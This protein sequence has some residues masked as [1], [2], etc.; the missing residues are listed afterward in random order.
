MAADGGPSGSTEPLVYVVVLSWNRAATTLRCIESVA[1]SSYRNA[2]V[3]VVDNA[4]ADDSVARIRERFPQVPLIQ[5]PANLGYA[6]GN[7][8]GIRY[9]MERGAEFVLVLNDDVF[10]EPDALGHMVAAAG[11]GVAAVGCKVRLFDEPDR[12]WAAGDLNFRTADA[13]P[14]DDGRFDAP[15]DLDYAVGCC[16]LLRAG[17]LDEIGR[18]DPSYFLEFEEVDWC[19]RARKAGHRIVYEP[20]AV[21]YHNHSVSFTDSCSPAFHYLSARNCL[22]FWKRNDVVLSGRP[23]ALYGLI[24][25]LAQLRLILR[26][27]GSKLRRIT[28]AT[29]GVVDYYRGRFG[30]PPPN[31]Y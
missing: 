16:I 7:N 31:L 29:L 13:H 30:A 28:A 8:V 10:I 5:N 17:V 18:F 25:W 6:E 11:P 19:S 14:K 26:T 4:S 12:L 3:V 24:S 1:G 20:R 27:R 22:L 21:V 23:R 2:R 15:R 9:A